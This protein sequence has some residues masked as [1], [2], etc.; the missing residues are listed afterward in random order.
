MVPAVL[1]EGVKAAVKEVRKTKTSLDLIARK[2]RKKLAQEIR[3]MN[4][5]TW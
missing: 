4:G 5:G 1:P 3:T 2:V